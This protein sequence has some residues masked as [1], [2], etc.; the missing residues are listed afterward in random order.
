MAKRRMRTAAKRIL[1]PEQT[2]KKLAGIYDRQYVNKKGMHITT[3]LYFNLLGAIIDLK[4][5]RKVDSVILGTLDN[6]AKR[7]AKI[8]K[9]LPLK[10]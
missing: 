1:T 3:H 4:E 10:D 7:V 2:L 5:Y 6:V 8:G 9:L